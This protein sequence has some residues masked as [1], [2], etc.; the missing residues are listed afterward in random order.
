MKKLIRLTVNEKA[1]QIATE[2]N[3]T[4]V[5]LLRCCPVRKKA[6]KWAIA[7]HVP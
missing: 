6:A 3:Q 2:P 5:D 7:A 1:Y 4:L